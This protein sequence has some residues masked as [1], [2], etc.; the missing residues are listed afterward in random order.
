MA[1]QIVGLAFDFQG[2]KTSAVIDTYRGSHS[3]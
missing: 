1:A 3:I 2:Q